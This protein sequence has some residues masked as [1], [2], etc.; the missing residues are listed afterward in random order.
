MSEIK[1]FDTGI[2]IE[3][4]IK[5]INL[6][7]KE[8][9]LNK[10]K[11]RNILKKISESNLDDLSHN[12]KNAYHENAEIY[13]FHPVN[14]LKG[15]DEIINTLWKPLI[16]SFPDLER[17]D[18]L[19]IGGSF[20]NRVYVS[21]VGHLTGTFAHPW[22]GV[23]SNGKTIHL[24][25]CEV[26]QIENES[27]ISSIET[28]ITQSDLS[29]LDLG[30]RTYVVQPGNSLWRIAR[31]IYGRGIMYIDIYKKNDHLIKDPNLIY[32]GQVFSLLD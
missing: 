21:T 8:N 23:P 13:A 15:V 10:K 3:S 12:I 24:R 31:R 25:I 20:Q 22:L 1:N 4:G 32:P 6:D 11:I 2:P 28:P 27:I 29:E 16:Y 17:R 18:N 9:I 7:P 5:I 26:H 30:D 19:I 14:E